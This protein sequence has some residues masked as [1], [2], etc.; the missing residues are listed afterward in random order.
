MAP[1]LR[2]V[3]IVTDEIEAGRFFEIGNKKAFPVLKRRV[4]GNA[5]SGKTT[6]SVS[7]L[8]DSPE[9]EQGNDNNK[10]VFELLLHVYTIGGGNPERQDNELVKADGLA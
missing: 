2:T 8:P 6:E 3:G 5:A 10:H 4:I 7:H 1:Q 9:C